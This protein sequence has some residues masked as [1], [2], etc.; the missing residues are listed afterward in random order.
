MH[1]LLLD[2]TNLS[3]EEFHT[4]RAAIQERMA[5]AYRIG[6]A[7]M[8]GQLQLI[9]QDYVVEMERRNQ[10]LLDQALKSGQLGNN[11]SAK[12]LTR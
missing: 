3:D 8:V 4:K 6:N 7:S 11:D 1:P 2:L 12:D 5:Y 9:A 10:K